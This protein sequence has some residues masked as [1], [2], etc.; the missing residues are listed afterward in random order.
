VIQARDIF[1][2]YVLSSQVNLNQVE[3]IKVNNSL[4]EKAYEN[5]F[6]ISFEQFRDTVILYLAAEDQEVY[7]SS[8]LWDEIKLKVADLIDELRR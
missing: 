4:L 7:N 6:Q 5:I 1:D 8:V 3:E 2:L